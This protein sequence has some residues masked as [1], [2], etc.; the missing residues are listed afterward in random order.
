LELL[1]T[2]IHDFKV[3]TEWLKEEIFDKYMNSG[4]KTKTAVRTLQIVGGA[5]V[6]VLVARKLV[7]MLGDDNHKQKA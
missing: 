5:V 3:T 1:P 7:Q 6:G 4:D 2:P